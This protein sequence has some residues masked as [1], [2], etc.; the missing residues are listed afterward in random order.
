MFFTE[1]LKNLQ[2]TEKNPISRMY[3]NEISIKWRKV[4]KEAKDYCAAEDAKI[5]TFLDVLNDFATELQNPK[6][7][8]DKLAKGGF[9]SNSELFS[10]AYI[11]DLITILIDKF[12]SKCNPGIRWGY[13]KFTSDLKLYEQN[14]ITC[15][16]NPAMKT[17]DSPKFLMLA[18][19]LDLQYR[20][21][22]KRNFTKNSITLPLI[23]VHTFRNFNEEH[24]IR[25]EHYS[26][27]AKKTFESGK[28]F[29]VTETI[30]QGFYPDIE[31]SSIDG[32]F[33]LRKHVKKS[34]N[35]HNISIEVVN[36]IEAK[37]K[38]FIE[39]KKTDPKDIIKT[40]YID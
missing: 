14:M 24:F 27:K 7:K 22:G 25:V 36:M 23:I 38:E 33:V 3:L 28:V 20:L 6:Y 21:A 32:I 31:N 13:Q 1:V 5:D 39:F 2:K 12:K 34:K 11:D 30:E 10:V 26:N 18:Q 16:K 4:E 19:R 37:F 29:I 15:T 40:G 8:A 35:N 17:K 9:K